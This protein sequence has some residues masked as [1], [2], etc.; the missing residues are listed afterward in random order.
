MVFTK[1]LVRTF[2]RRLAWRAFTWAENLN[3]TR[4]EQNGE[5]LFLAHLPEVEPFVFFDVGA[6]MGEYSLSLLKRFPKAE[7]HLFEPSSECLKNLHSL[8]AEQPQILG[9]KFTFF[10]C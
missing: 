6:N 7:G 10:N 5:D 4:M 2:I 9:Y 8:F 3:D 1:S